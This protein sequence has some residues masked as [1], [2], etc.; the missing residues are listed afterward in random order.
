MYIRK[1]YKDMIKNLIFDV[2]GVLFDY[3]WK[4]MFMDYGLDEDNAIRVGT[5][6]FNDPDRTWDI[7]DLG[8]KSDEEIADIFCKKYPGDE[9][10]IRWFIRHGEYMQVP[11]PKVWKKVHELKQKGYKIYILSNYSESLFKKHTEY[12]DFMDD[13]DGLMVSYMIHKAKPAEDIYKA[14]CDKYG[15]DRSESIFFDDRSENVEGAIK[16]GMKS[17]KILSE[18]VLLDELDRF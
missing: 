10:V 9:D 6:M 14:L 5:Q 16:F 7:F 4:E 15:L 12:A 8:I 3:R 11:R 18:Q 1:G 2:G 13:I 17:V